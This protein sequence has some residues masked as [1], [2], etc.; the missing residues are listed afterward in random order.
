M[1]LQYVTNTLFKK[2]DI[3]T[4]KLG[5]IPSLISGI[6]L[7]SCVIIRRDRRRKYFNVSVMHG[8]N[9]NTDH[10]LVRPIVLIGEASF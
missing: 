5:S 1:G 7:I 6:V 3:Y 10:H 4:S 8:A 2:K 9:C